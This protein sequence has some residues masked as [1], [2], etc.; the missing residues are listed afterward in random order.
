MKFAKLLV[1][2]SKSKC[3]SRNFYQDC[4]PPCPP[5]SR[6]LTVALTGVNS[7]VGQIT[8][9]V[10]KQCQFID[11]L[12]VFDYTDGPY[13]IS[14]D[15]GHI[16]TNTKITGYTGL[17]CLREA[18]TGANVVVICGGEPQKPIQNDR[19]LFKLNADYVRNV[20]LH[21][22]E[23]NPHA[24]ICV[25]TPPVAAMV[26]LISEEYKR[27]EVYNARKIIGITTL[28]SSRA[29][30][31]IGQYAQKDPQTINCPL[32][33][34]DRSNTIVPVLS[35]TEV[36]VKLPKPAV[37]L[38][39]NQICKAEDEALVK[40]YTENSGPCAISAA[41]ATSKFVISVVRGLLDIFYGVECAYVRQVGHCG[42]FLPY[43]TSVVKLG[44]EGVQSIHMPFISEQECEKLQ[45]AAKV[46]RKQIKWGESYITG[47]LLEKKRRTRRPL[48][49]CEIIKI[50]RQTRIGDAAFNKEH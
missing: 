50:E 36:G 32:V 49:T 16:D 26:P 19:E 2:C 23:F 28:G 13:G 38:L 42:V 44:L 35:Q 20:A 24:I 31:I 5:T 4:N 34:A 33:G 1:S 46:I 29:N 12:N 45:K 22:A 3:L 17:D 6:P 43:M 11:Q 14:V 40:K 30:S 41:Y 10:L 37:E 39:H 15:L 27:A 9:L 7:R 48:H 18:V 21:T 47:E 8:S 25:S